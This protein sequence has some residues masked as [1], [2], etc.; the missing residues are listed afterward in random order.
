MAG[1][2]WG[3]SLQT[4]IDRYVYAHCVYNEGCNAVYIL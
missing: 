4:D 1:F 3:G 2:K